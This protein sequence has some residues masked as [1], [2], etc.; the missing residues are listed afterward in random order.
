[1]RLGKEQAAGYVEDIESDVTEQV[2][3]PAVA[4]GAD[5]LPVAAEQE[6]VTLPR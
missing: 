2:L 1:M 4:V 6:P 3:A 5:S